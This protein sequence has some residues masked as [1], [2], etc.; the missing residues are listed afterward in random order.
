MATA[1]GEDGVVSKKAR[2]EKKR[3]EREMSV[4]HVAIFG[5]RREGVLG[6]D[7]EL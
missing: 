7:W 4:C 2:Q 6:G 3:R 5:Q 1:V